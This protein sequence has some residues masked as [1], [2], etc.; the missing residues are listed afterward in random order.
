MDKAS[1]IYRI[2]GWG[3]TL[4]AP[5][6]RNSAIK[7]NIKPK[8]EYDRQRESI[9]KII[10]SRPL[11]QSKNDLSKTYL[12]EMK[13]DTNQ[14]Y[15]NFDEMWQKTNEELKKIKKEYVSVDYPFL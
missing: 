6:A 4:N 9:D 7:I 8:N 2:S 13:K 10:R 1:E 5:F 3:E 14:T 15:K 11:Y 12:K